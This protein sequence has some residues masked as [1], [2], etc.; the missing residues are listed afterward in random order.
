MTYTS[1]CFTS[2][3]PAGGH[4]NSVKIR[5]DRGYETSYSHLSAILV[6]NGAKVRQGA[7]I[8]R[9]GST[10]LAT[11]PHLHFQMWKHGRYVDAMREDMPRSLELPAHLKAP[12]QEQVT[13][14]L[15]QVPVAAPAVQARR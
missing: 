4:G 8:G 15:P 12:F 7:V 3:G 11:G 10:G 9:V 1:F 2:A 6:K 14:W 5:H 13:R